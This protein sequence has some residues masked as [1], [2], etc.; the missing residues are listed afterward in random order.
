MLLKSSRAV[1]VCLLLSVLLLSSLVTA[2]D[3]IQRFV[4]NTTV[5]NMY[6]APSDDAEV[7]SQAIYTSNVDLLEAREGWFKIRT[8]DDYTGWMKASTL[9]KLDGTPYASS[10]RIVRVVQFSANIYREPDVT[11]HAPV[12]TA[13]WE[14]RLAVISDVGANHRWL[15]VKLPDGAEAYV[16]TGDVASDFKALNIDQTIALAKKFLGVTYTWGGTSAAGYDCSGFVQMLMRQR[17]IVMPRDAKV[18]VLWSGVD[19]VKREDLKPGDLLYFGSDVNKVTH[20]G[21][22]I[23]NGEFIHDTTHE[24]PMIQVNKLDDMPWTKLLVAAR[25]AK[26]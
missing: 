11:S 12:V 24:H 25:R 15:K 18:Q 2:Q 16:Q 4:V 7:I 9:K 5:A 10:G 19:A 22:Y 1:V 26:Q 23:G 20:T 13:P 6:R 21:M 3:S 14:S 17:G 8:A